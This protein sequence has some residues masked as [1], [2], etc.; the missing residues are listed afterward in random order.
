[1][2][3]ERVGAN[4]TPYGGNVRSPEEKV[5]KDSAEPAK[6][7]SPEKKGKESKDE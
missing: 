3:E 4:G 5:V 1:M 7:K 6:V 2:I